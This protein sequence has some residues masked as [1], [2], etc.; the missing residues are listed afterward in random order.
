[1]KNPDL[2]FARVAERLNGK[3]PPLPAGIH[4]SA[5]VAPGAS[6]GKDVAMGAYTVVEEG[7]SIGDGTILYPQIYV[8]RDAKVGP[9][10]LI[11]P[12]VV[13]REQCLIGARVILHSGA[14]IGSDGF[15]FTTDKGVHHKV[16]QIGIVVV[17]DD[18]EI[19]ANTSIDRARFGRTV[20]GCGTKIDNLVQ[21]AHNVVIG[22]GSLI[23][24]LA[25]ISGSTRLGKF[26]M[27]AGQVGISPHMEI[28]DGVVAT[29]QSGIAK[30]LPPGMQVTGH[31]AMESKKYFRQRAALAHLPKALK[32]LKK[33]KKEVEELRR[34]IAGGD[35]TSSKS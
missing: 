14:I 10:S 9:G 35:S 23:A 3:T 15:G 33:L 19:G 32:E 25:G 20:I 2:A 8:G 6:I 27:I 7:A 17:E 31:H 24:A 22:P 13:I 26:V 11:Y 12:Q 5:V 29:A 21:I 28:G 34:R 18:V 1:M 30:N 16:P 4:P